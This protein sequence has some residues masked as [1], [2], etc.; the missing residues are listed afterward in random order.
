M[1][2]ETTAYNI[3]AF[4]FEGQD[5]A[6]ETM[7]EIKSSGVLEGYKI[8]AQA[9]VEQ[10]TKGKV[11]IHEPGKGGVGA[12]VGGTAGGILALIGGPVGVLSWVVSG[13]IIGGVAGKHLG[14][15]I[16]KGDLEDI[17]EAMAPDSSTILLLLENTYI[18]DVINNMADYGGSVVTLTIGDELSGEIESYVAIED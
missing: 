9:V 10:D 11:H 6:S 15:P 3:L 14:R 12:F 5:K 13:A 18:K 7:K 1:S 8:V 2:Y 17:G 4:T 16:S